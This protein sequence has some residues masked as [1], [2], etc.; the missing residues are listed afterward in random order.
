MYQNSWPLLI[1]LALSLHNCSKAQPDNPVQASEQSSY[2]LDLVVGDVE[3]PWSI[4]QLPDGSLLYTEK[5]GLLIRFSSGTKIIIHDFEN[6]FTNGQAGLFDVVLDPDYKTNGWL[7][8]AIATS[9]DGGKTGNTEIF[10]TKLEN[11]K[12]TNLESLYKGDPDTDKPYHFGGRI[13]FDKEG[14][15]YFAIGD[16]GNRDENPQ[17]ITRDGGKIYRINRDGTIP[18][19]NPFYNSPG[20]KKAIYSY[21]HRNP[22]GLIYN[23][24]VDQIWDSEHGPRGG[25]EMNIIRAGENNGWPVISYGINYN[26]TK[27]TDI[28]KKEGMQDP[29]LYWVPS[30]A[31]CGM[32]YVT[33][34]YYPEWKGDILI[35]SLKFRYLNRC[36]MEGAKVVKQERLFDNKGRVRDVFQA[37]DGFIYVSIE[38]EGIYKVIK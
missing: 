9:S 38:Y 27:F 16:R 7:Y 4:A 36:D 25:D 30:I 26:G 24:A 33:S 21:G 3:I 32:D 18:T 8:L 29:L 11:N 35:G 14:Y 28:T 23:P 13:A 15:L 17:D 19:D 31:P 10:R 2:K 22:Q 37:P 5:A 12:L 1:I 20:A 6:V 34:D